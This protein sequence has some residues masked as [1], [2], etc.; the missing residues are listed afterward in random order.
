[1]ARRKALISAVIL[2]AAAIASGAAYWYLIVPPRAVLLLP[3]GDLLLYVNI[4]PLHLFQAHPTSRLR[5][6]PEYGH[7]IENTGF[8]FER[9]LDEI[10]VS[11]HKPSRA[12]DT[13]SSEIF[14]GR[15][16]RPRMNS[17]LGK[18]ASGTENYAGRTIYS[19]PHQG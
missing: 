9:D 3:D 12:A 4:Q 18:I 19:I 11:Q 1:M 15:F 8:Q 14:I 17:Y 16:D 13:E 7:F 6:D 10:A 5:L 2:L